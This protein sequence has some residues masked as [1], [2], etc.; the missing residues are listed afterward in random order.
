MADILLDTNVLIDFL[1]GYP[2]ADGFFAQYAIADRLCSV[3]TL[4]EL[5]EGCL[6]GMEQKRL[7]RFLRSFTAIPIEREDSLT[8]LNWFRKWR[9]SHGVDMLDC[10]IGA[11]ARRLQIPFFTRDQLHFSLFP[12][13]D[14]R[15]PY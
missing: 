1:R 2:P 10:L 14:V 8:A 15:L 13:I 4:F 12:D 11:T 7:D 5:Y 6:N 3:V 9:L